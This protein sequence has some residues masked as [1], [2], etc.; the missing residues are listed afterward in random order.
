MS[1]KNR[2][3]QSAVLLS[4]LLSPLSGVELYEEKKVSHIQIELDSSAPSLSFDPKPLLSKMKT[5]EGDDFS[6]FTFDN[7]LKSLSEEYDRVQPS[8]RVED[9][10]VSITIV[11]TPRPI[12]HQIRI[13][14]N[15]RYSTS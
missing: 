10:Q 6:Q 3:L 1:N 7:D 5:K 9:N 12:I 13:Q 15:E 11:V 14:G 8:L 4:M 2:L